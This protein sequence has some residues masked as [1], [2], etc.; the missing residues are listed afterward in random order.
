MVAAFQ[1]RPDWIRFP[2]PSEAPHEVIY[3]KI[4][5]KPDVER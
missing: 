3:V 2:V 5:F 4:R 1:R